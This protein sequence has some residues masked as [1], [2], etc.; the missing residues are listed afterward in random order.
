M[1]SVH[2]AGSLRR[3]GSGHL[4][5]LGGLVEHTPVLSSTRVFSANLSQ[6]L[7]ISRDMKGQAF[8]ACLVRLA[9]TECQAPEAIESPKQAVCSCKPMSTKPRGAKGIWAGPRT[10]LAAVS[11]PAT[12]RNSSLL[13]P[14]RW[15]PPLNGTW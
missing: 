14:P 6:S 13:P 4:G 1:Q 3:R 12:P 5:P 11:F 10:G 15:P 2:G 7:T 8:S 9:Y